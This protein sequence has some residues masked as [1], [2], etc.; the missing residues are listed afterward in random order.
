MQ[1][2]FTSATAARKAIKMLMESDGLRY[3]LEKH[4]ASLLPANTVNGWT[5]FCSIPTS[6]SVNE[7][8]DLTALVRLMLGE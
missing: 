7:T 3:R 4:G 6:V 8:C 2:L 1:T 5:V